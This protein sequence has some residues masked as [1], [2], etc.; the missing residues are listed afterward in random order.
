M[1]FTKFPRQDPCL[2]CK[3]QK[4]RAKEKLAQS[5]LMVSLRVQYLGSLIFK[6]YLMWLK[7]IM[8]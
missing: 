2:P 8:L 5:P 3:N 7:M 6:K 4:V 1:I